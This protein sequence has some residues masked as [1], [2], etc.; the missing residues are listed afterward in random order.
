MYKIG[1]G[2]FLYYHECI[3]RTTCIICLYVC[4]MK[5][6]LIKVK[7]LP[8]LNRGYELQYFKLLLTS[9]DASLL[10]KQQ[11]TTTRI[12]LSVIGHSNLHRRRRNYSG[13]SSRKSATLST[14]KQQQQLGQRLCMMLLTT[15]TILIVLI[16][17]AKT[18]IF[19]SSKTPSLIPFRKNHNVKRRIR[20]G[21]D[22]NN[23]NNNNTIRNDGRKTKHTD[24]SSS[25][26]LLIRTKSKQPH[27]RHH[28]IDND[29]KKEAPWISG[30]KNSLASGLAAGC[31]KLI[32]APLDTIKTLQQSSSMMATMPSSAGAGA[33]A[34]SLRHAAQTIM[35]RPKGLLEFYVRNFSLL[36]SFVCFLHFSSL[37]NVWISFF[38]FF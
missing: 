20:N 36:F 22:N 35:K 14:M 3:C 21:S 12:M 9:H 13:F 10:F 34:L 32:L 26:L 15:T 28:R 29:Q 1:S 38:F 17:T 30:F 4:A 11:E 6:K 18:V 25:S 7:N 31:S 33:G 27:H 23:T 16:S 5:M 37:K 2:L 24:C 8:L 19:V